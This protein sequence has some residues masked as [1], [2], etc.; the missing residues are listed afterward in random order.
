MLVSRRNNAQKICLVLA[1]AAFAPAA[2]STSLVVGSTL[3][4]SGGSIIGVTSWTFQCNQPGDS[5]CAAPPAGSGDFTVANSTGTFAQYNGS[6]GL[7]KSVNDAIQPLNTPFSLPNWITFD[8]NNQLTLELTFLP[9]GNDPLSS[10]CAGLSHCTPT[11]PIL[12]TP[13]D[14]GGLT[15]FNFD[16]NVT[17]TTGTIGV[18]GIAH[19]SD[20]STGSFA[21]TFSSTFTGS[22]PQ[23]ALALILSGNPQTYQ[24]SIVLTAINSVPEPM[25]MT[26]MGVGLFGLLGRRLYAC[27]KAEEP[28]KKRSF[29]A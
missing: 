1:L 21:G 2:R 26:L 7:L 13:S 23:E 19:A 5:V 10:D 20:G 3:N 16:Q 29:R 8:L 4:F 6:F 28:V 11:S 25:S 17:G 9:L 24:G 22:N 27:R 12:I 15:G 18:L 14:P